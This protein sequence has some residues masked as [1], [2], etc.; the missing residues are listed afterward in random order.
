VFTLRQ[1]SRILDYT[2]NRNPCKITEQ[3][4]VPRPLIRDTGFRGAT[5]DCNERRK[6]DFRE[7]NA[8][9]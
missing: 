7:R 1:F 8:P 3:K 9:E 2:T 5:R 4:P 6:D